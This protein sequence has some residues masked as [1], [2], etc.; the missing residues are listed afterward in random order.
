MLRRVRN[1]PFIIIIII[2][3]IGKRHDLQGQRSR[4]QDHVVRV[5]DVGP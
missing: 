4:S 3:I 1:C 2:I 5:T